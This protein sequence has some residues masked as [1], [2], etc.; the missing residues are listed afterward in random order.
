MERQGNI[1]ASTTDLLRLRVK[2]PGFKGLGFRNQEPL[3]MIFSRQSGAVGCIRP[4]SLQRWL[5]FAKF[6]LD[7]IESRIRACR[8]CR[9]RQNPVITITILAIIIIIMTIIIMTIIIII[10]ILIIITIIIIIIIIITITAIILVIIIIII[11]IM[12]SNTR[13]TVLRSLHHGWG[14]LVNG[15]AWLLLSLKDTKPGLL[16]VRMKQIRLPKSSP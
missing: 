1:Q 9:N 12:Y 8:G 15:T 2:G 11:V 16:P 7:S 3:N 5:S 13:T 4:E 6:L 14:S 10:I